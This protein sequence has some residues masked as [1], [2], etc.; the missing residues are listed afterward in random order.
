MTTVRSQLVKFKKAGKS[1]QHFISSFIKF[2]QIALR[3]PYAYVYEVFQKLKYACAMLNWSG[4]VW[5][6]C[7]FSLS[8]K[9]W[10]ESRC[11]LQKVEIKRQ[12]KTI[13]EKF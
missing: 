1:S 11:Y 4:L 9:T 6:G 3:V 12:I 10:R 8:K 13:E 2:N 7:P 5:S